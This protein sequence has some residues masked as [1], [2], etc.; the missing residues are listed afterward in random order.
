LDV[1]FPGVPENLAGIKMELEDGMT[2]HSKQY[3][4]S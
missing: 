4:H 3:H 2:N 1:G